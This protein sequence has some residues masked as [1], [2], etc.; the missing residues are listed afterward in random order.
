MTGLVVGVAATRAAW[1]AALRSYVRDHT[2]GIGIEVV[3]DR[4]G[5]GRVAGKLDVL[6]LDDVMRIFSTAE[7]AGA[8]EN[9]V[10]VIG[11]Y[12][13]NSGMGRDYLTRL[14]VDQ[15]LPAS[16]PPA[17]VVAVISQRGPR[18]R[19]RT[20]APGAPRLPAASRPA[21]GRKPHGLLSAWTKVSGGAGLTEALVAAA[22]HLSKTGRVLVIE[23]DEVAPVL[24]SRLLRSPD[25]GLAW[26]VSRAGQG[27]KVLPGGLSGPRGDGTAAIGHFD[28]ICGT[29]G[30]AQVINA[31]H[32]VRLVEEA[33]VFYDQVL[34]EA[35]W[36][37]GSP[38]GRERFGAARAVLLLADRVVVFASADPEGGAR[39][40]EWRASSVAAGVQAP[41]WAVFGRARSSRYERSHLASLLAGNT[42]DHPFTGVTFLPEDPV[43][44]RA[45]WNAE[46]VWKGPWSRAVRALASVTTSS[47]GARP[48]SNERASV[49]DLDI[50][51]PG[52]PEAAEAV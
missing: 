42:G 49:A 18:A 39:L 20:G 13:H 8:Q 51:V 9:G 17:E 5:L 35:S 12:D 24:V 7:I 28:V 25:T 29:P 50:S 21:G 40:V 11:L 31:V 14:G 45:R 15:V 19:A 27:Q 4:S 6:L 30:A 44:A 23:A 2:Q 41:C 46:V 3:M 34:V 52:A 33:L 43:V 10:H 16:T 48:A 36:L 47:G 37:V 1:S 22:A 32:L 38:S 26:A